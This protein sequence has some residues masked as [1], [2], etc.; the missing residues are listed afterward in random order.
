MYDTLIAQ[1]RVLDG[2]GGPETV[3]DVAL[4][5]DRIA[6]IGALGGR[7]AAAP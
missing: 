4:A 1:V 2:S 5:G 6:A 7:P 3:A